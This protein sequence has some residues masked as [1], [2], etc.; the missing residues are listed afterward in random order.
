[1]PIMI[2]GYSMEVTTNLE[3]FLQGYVISDKDEAGQER[4]GIWIDA[5]CINQ[6]DIEERNIQVKRMRDIYSQASGAILWLGKAADDSDKAMDM[7]DS[8]AQRL[9]TTREEM[10][11]YLQSIR[12]N[13][14]FEPG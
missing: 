4:M 1:R 12:E 6:S 9:F 10:V 3:D 11:G 8:V 5:I 7:I 14:V 13:P 2:N